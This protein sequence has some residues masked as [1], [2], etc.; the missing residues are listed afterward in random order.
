MRSD[1][2]LLKWY[3]IINKKFFDGSCP[4]KVCVRWSD[5]NSEVEKGVHDG[6]YFG[7][8]CKVENDPYHEY[9]IVMCKKL[10]EKWAVRMSTLVHEMIHL[11]NG[12]R[13]NHGPAFELVER[14][15]S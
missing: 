13:D 15:K 2:T 5:P 11:A 3:K 7:W 8:A 10:N 6:K 12:L 9:E 1:Q 4:T 14:A